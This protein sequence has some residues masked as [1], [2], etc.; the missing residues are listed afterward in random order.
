MTFIYYIGASPPAG[1][2]FDSGP[3]ETLLLAV[4]GHH[5]RPSRE[6]KHFAFD[7]KRNLARWSLTSRSFK[8]QLEYI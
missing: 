6:G 2:G 3:L 4:S 7:D 5:A 1:L 8:I